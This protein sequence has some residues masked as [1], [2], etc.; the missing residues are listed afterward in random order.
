M[1]FSGAQKLWKDA[2]PLNGKTFSSTISRLSIKRW[3]ILFDFPLASVLPLIFTFSFLLLRLTWNPLDRDR[4][5]CQA[6]CHQNPPVVIYSACI[7]A[8]V[9]YSAYISENRDYADRL[10]I[11]FADSLVTSELLR[12]RV[13]AK[14]TSRALA[15]AKKRNLL[16]PT[17]FSLFA[18]LPGFFPVSF[19]PPQRFPA[20]DMAG[21]LI[22]IIDRGIIKVALA[23]GRFQLRIS[24]SLGTIGSV[25]SGEGEREGRGEGKARERNRGRMVEESSVSTVRSTHPLP[26]PSGG[27]TVGEQRARIFS[28]NF[29][30][31]KIFGD[32]L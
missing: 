24:V 31:P 1:D 21:L 32:Y 10:S 26:A 27:Q 25:G 13:R 15:R 11:V 14:R 6:Q 16:F 5:N 22:L 17:C 20:C 30:K 29:T 18:K 9:T 23:R 19:F 2:A 28:I 4:C 8:V 12:K 3:R 7:S